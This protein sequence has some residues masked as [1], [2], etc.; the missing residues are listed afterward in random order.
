MKQMMRP[1][2]S[3]MQQSPSSASHRSLQPSPRG[4]TRGMGA[5]FNAASP[6]GTPVGLFVL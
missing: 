5:V 6:S 3:P 2:A 4:L 1:G